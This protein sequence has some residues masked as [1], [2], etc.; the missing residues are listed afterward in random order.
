M[1]YEAY[2]AGSARLLARAAE[3]LGKTEDA[4]EYHRLADGVASAFRRTYVSPE[5]IVRGDT[6]CAYVLA[7][8][9]D[10][11]DPA[12]AKT[13]AARLVADIEARGDHLS[14]GFVGTRDLM[15]VLSKIGRD[16]V[17]FRLLHQRTFPSWGFEIAHG[18]T[19]VWERWDGWTPEKGF[20]DPGMNSF[21]HYAYGAVMGWVF[22]TV[23]GIGNEAPGFEKIRIATAIDPKLTWAKT[24]YD[25]VRGPDPHRVADR[26]R[27]ADPGR[28]DPPERHRRGPRCR[29]G[30]ARWRATRRRQGRPEASANGLRARLGGLPLPHAVEAVEP[31]LS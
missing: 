20:Q 12:Q 7:L 8:G 30:A 16:D 2:F 13:A 24:S 10:L 17:A 27:R 15:R 22:E 3:A 11:L 23:G 14:T 25:S 18:A 19:T 1:I 26:G 6:Q 21:A 9:F 28:R 5:G 4:A 31:R 29:P